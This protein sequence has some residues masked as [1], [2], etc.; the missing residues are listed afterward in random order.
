MQSRGYLFPRVRL[1]PYEFFSHTCSS[2]GGF[3]YL[4]VPSTFLELRCGVWVVSYVAMYQRHSIPPNSSKIVTHSQLR[5]LSVYDTVARVLSCH[6]N[7]GQS[8]PLPTTPPP[9]PIHIGP[10]AVALHVPPPVPGRLPQGT[11]HW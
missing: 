7:N 10:E 4:F 1:F 2:I 6:V 5:A 3:N 11:D 8:S 9:T